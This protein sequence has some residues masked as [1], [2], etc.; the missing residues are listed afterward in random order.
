MTRFNWLTVQF[1][2]SAEQL[3]KRRMPGGPLVSTLW[4]LLKNCANPSSESQAGPAAAALL[5]SPRR[6]VSSWLLLWQLLAQLRHQD[7]ES[8]T[9]VLC[10]V[11]ISLQRVFPCSRPC[12]L[13]GFVTAVEIRVQSVIKRKLSVPLV[14]S[15]PLPI[16]MPVFAS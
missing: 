14:A 15:Y 11:Y 3:L 2:K 10:V 8:Y 9:I 16:S 1:I 12:L 7:K 6:L 4:K 13:K 5:P